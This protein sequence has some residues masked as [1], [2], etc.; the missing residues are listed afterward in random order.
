[1]RR[2]FVSLYLLILVAFLGL[3]RGL[4]LAW[5]AWRSDSVDAP[6]EDLLYSIG[7]SLNALPAEARSGFLAAQPAP[8]RVIDAADVHLAP[9]LA[10]RLAAGRIVHLAQG[11]SGE[12]YAHALKGGRQLLLYGPVAERNPDGRSLFLGLFFL[13]LAAVV[14]LWS[15]PLYR[16]LQRLRNAAAA[17]GAGQLPTRVSLAPHSLV[18][19]LGHSFN[20]MAGRIEQLVEDQRLMARAVAHDLRTPL[21]R[22]HFALAMLPESRS[23]DTNPYLASLREDL[24]FIDAL[25]QRLLD[26]TQLEQAEGLLRQ[27]VPLAAFVAA[28]LARYDP[29]GRIGFHCQLGEERCAHLDPVLFESLLQNLVDNARR[30]AREQVRVSLGQNEQRLWLAVEDD[31]PGIPEAQRA[32]IFKPFARLDGARNSAQQAHF[33]LGLAIVERIVRHHGAEI[34]VATSA[35]GGACFRLA[36]PESSAADPSPLMPARVR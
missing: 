22:L 36:I 18:A 21:S 5:D 10:T 15:W 32:F 6:I 25:L 35:L 27:S 26:F 17:F 2:L 28:W 33:G 31:G 29:Q 13:L 34:R 12:F 9:A 11:E 30:H 23:N 8:L 20:A 7:A 24:D 19:D 1:M 3:G 14:A 4:D 16:D